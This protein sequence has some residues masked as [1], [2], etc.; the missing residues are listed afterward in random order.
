MVVIFYFSHGIVYI[1]VK[2]AKR[3]TRSNRTRRSGTHLNITHPHHP[4]A[5]RRHPRSMMRGGLTTLMPEI[6]TSAT[7]NSGSASSVVPFGL[8]IDTQEKML[9]PP[10][11]SGGRRR[12]RRSSSSSSSSSSKRS[13]R[14]GSWVN[15]I[16]QALVPFGLAAMNHRWSKRRQSK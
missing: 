9:P 5:S 2:M 1:V 14:G 6:Y 15:V 11:Q 13:K 16:Q 10:A 3:R 7:G 12:Q 8:T 4:S